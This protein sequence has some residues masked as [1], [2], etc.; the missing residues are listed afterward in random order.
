MLPRRETTSRWADICLYTG[1]ERSEVDCLSTTDR[2]SLR[3]PG[4]CLIC[5]CKPVPG[6]AGWHTRASYYIWLS[7]EDTGTKEPHLF[8]VWEVFS[9]Q[10]H[11]IF[12]YALILNFLEIELSLSL[13]YFTAAY[14]TIFFLE[15]LHCFLR[16][17]CMIVKKHIQD[18]FL[19]LVIASE[20]VLTIFL[21]IPNQ[22]FGTSCA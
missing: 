4:I 21:F 3:Q 10:P 14:R 20:F 9:Q 8:A 12:F 19:C 15:C 6:G 7:T 5:I 17:N 11:S 22:S 18:L 1:S 16:V 13:L 2:G